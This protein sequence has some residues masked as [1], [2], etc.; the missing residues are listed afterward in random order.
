MDSC[1]PESRP[2]NLPRHIAISA[3][4]N[5]RWASERGLTRTEGHRS[6][7]GAFLRTLV[8]CTQLRIPFLSIHAFSPE[9]WQRPVT[10]VDTVVETFGVALH[11]SREAFDTL[12]VK[13]V[14]SGEEHP[15]PRHL[16]DQ[17]RA[18]ERHT[19]ANSTLTLQLCLNYG[20]H[21]EMEF[22]ASRLAHAIRTSDL[23]MNASSPSL[24]DFFY[25]PEVPDVDLYIRPGRRARVSNFLLW[26]MAYAEIVFTDT[27]WPDFRNE[28]LAEAISRYQKSAR[29]F[30]GATS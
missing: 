5:G 1:F 11:R 8:G 30:G 21:T 2:D 26:Q 17:L 12:G 9:N 3:D 25:H 7:I 28:D 19:S 24:R 16:I 4:G 27:L 10:E 18:V 22:A 14:W 6:S 20:G 29:T 13:V 15:L 23:D